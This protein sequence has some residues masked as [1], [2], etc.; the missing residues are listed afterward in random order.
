MRKLRS[1]STWNQITPEQRETLEG[2]LFDENL[3]YAEALERAQKEFGLKA[4]LASLGRYCRRVALER[5][6]AEL[7]EAQVAANELNDQPVCI[8]SLRAAAVKLAGK[9][10][11]KLAGEQPE[12]LKQMTALTRLLLES[13]D[14]ETRRSRLKLEEKYFHLEATAASI[15]ECPRLRA[16]LRVLVEDT[17]LS[18]DERL[19]RMNAIL[20]GGERSKVDLVKTDKSKN[21]S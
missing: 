7:L 16:Y 5:Q 4:T 11:L 6:I 15:K 13:A 14:T 2:W 8:D 21:G 3:G 10:L 19:K 1:D 17:S 20:F 18:K 12:Q 9:T